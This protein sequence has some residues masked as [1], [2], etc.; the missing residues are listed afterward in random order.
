MKQYKYPRIYHAS[1]EYSIVNGKYTW[2][3]TT[4]HPSYFSTYEEVLVLTNL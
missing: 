4:N 2:Q 3:L 1:L